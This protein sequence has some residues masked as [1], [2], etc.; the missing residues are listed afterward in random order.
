MMIAQHY[1]QKYEESGDGDVLAEAIDSA[2][3]VSID[4]VIQTLHDQV[5]DSGKTVSIDGI[6][7]TRIESFYPLVI[8]VTKMLGGSLGG[9]L[10]LLYLLTLIAFIYG[11][12]YV[13]GLITDCRYCRWLG[14]N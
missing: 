1:S 6:S 7:E 8:G 3:T 11:A 13:S 12:W 5:I 9:A 2:E 14:Q 10:L 4:G